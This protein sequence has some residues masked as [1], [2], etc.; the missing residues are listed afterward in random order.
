MH[1]GASESIGDSKWNRINDKYQTIFVQ[2]K[3]CRFFWR[4]YK[5]YT[6]QMTFKEE[7]KEQ[8]KENVEKIIY[9]CVRDFQHVKPF[10][11]IKQS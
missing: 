9:F 8:L 2:D 1:S 10:L 7:K 3:A 11:D 4:P 6:S 5:L